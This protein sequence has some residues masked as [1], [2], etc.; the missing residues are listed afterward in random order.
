MLPSGPT[1]GDAPLPMPSAPAGGE[2][3]VTGVPRPGYSAKRKVQRIDPTPGASAAG[4]ATAYSLP[5]MLDTYTVPS[6]PSAGEA[7]RT[8]PVW[9]DHLTSPFGA[10]AD[11]RPWPPMA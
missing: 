3:L 6:W 7:F 5:F 4:G 11:R 9:A 10:I 1:I 8:G 2:W